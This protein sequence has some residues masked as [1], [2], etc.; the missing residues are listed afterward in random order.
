ML[1]GDLNVSVILT[2]AKVRFPERMMKD[3]VINTTLEVHGQLHK[4]L[5]SYFQVPATEIAC[6][7]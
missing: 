5:M 6:I 1:L 3:F 2:D 7:I 4:L